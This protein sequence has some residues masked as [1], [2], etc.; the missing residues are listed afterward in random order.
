MAEEVKEYK[1]KI[2]DTRKTAPGLRIF[3]IE[4]PNY[5]EIKD[6]EQDIKLLTKVWN[7]TEEWI[8]QWNQWKDTQ[9]SNIESESLQ[10]I[11]GISICKFT[12]VSIFILYL[13]LYLHS[14]LYSIY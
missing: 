4:Q 13:Y 6:T 14:Y 10:L 7:L 2:L 5:K 3:D 12:F 1:A 8:N 9:V 11:A